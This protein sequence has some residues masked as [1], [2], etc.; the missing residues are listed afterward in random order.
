MKEDHPLFQ[1]QSLTFFYPDQPQPAVSDCTLSLQRGECF[2]LC[3]P[4]GSGKSTLLRQLKT[5][6][7]PHGRR[8]GTI[9]FRG[10]PL[11]HV[12]A[13]TQAAAIGFVTQNPENQIVTDQVWHELSFGLE[14][15][16]CDPQTIR[17]RVAET[18]SFFGIQTWFQRNVAELSGGQKQLLNLA[19]VMVMQPEV[20]ILDEPTAQL[21]PIAASDFLSALARI[22]RELGTTV[23][24]SEHRLEE[25]MAMADRAAVMSDGKILCLGT[26]QEVGQM[27]K[28]A[29][30]PMFR[31]MP[32][33]MRV[34]AAV[35]TGKSCPVTVRDGCRWLAAYAEDHPLKPLPAEAPECQPGETIL[36]AD[37]LHFRYAADGADVICGMNLTLRRG[38]LTALLGGNGTG[39]TTALKLLAGLQK[40]RCG[41]VLCEGTV[42]YLPQNPQTLFLKKTLRADLLN[43]KEPDAAARQVIRLCRLE[44]LLDRHPYDLSG[45]EQ[46]RAALAKLLM[47]QPDV[48]L[49]DEPTKGLDAEFKALFAAILR[50]LLNRGATILVASHDVEFCA[51]Y[52]DRCA[53]FFGGTVVSE[54]P[55]RQFFTGGTF[56]T[57]AA[58]R[59][60]HGAAAEVPNLPEAVTAEEL[61]AVCGGDVPDPIDLP[62]LPSDRPL[63]E[64]A[65]G[66]PND[67]AEKLPR[68]RKI[69]AVVA[70]TG[71][72]AVMAYASTHTEL[73]RPGELISK[74]RLL[75]YGALFALL[76][77]FAALVSRR[78]AKPP[79]QMPKEK[80]PKRTIA[81]SI[82][83][84]L[85]IP[86]TL[87]GGTALFD[88]RRYYLTA[89]LVL[90]ECMAPF[91]L[92]FEGR[93]PQARELVIIAVLCA[94]G[95]AGRAVFFMLPQFKPVM[96]IA[97]L[98]GAAFGGETGFL[99]GAVTMLASNL[100]FS[101]GP[102]TPWQMFAMGLVGFLAGL[103][104]K[105]GRLLARRAQLSIFGALCALIVYGGIMN[106]ASALMW[107][108]NLTWEILLPYYLTGCPMD[109]I[110]AAATAFFL[111]IAAEPMLEKLVR[112]KRKYGL[113]EFR[114]KTDGMHR[115]D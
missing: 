95:V 9:H 8:M 48:L 46:Q 55:P 115:A 88:G 53:L 82:S 32:T 21:D 57:T 98:A 111:W 114:P 3:G 19:A 35:P 12:D 84:L 92:L 54:A 83:I 85:L 59:M 17:R 16:G 112:M 14:S 69:G 105:R 1:V 77:L 2:V 25:A 7:A 27:L 49:M 99:V 18:A 109:C 101:Q 33:P 90:L 102:W 20:L 62:E 39:K 43:G 63:P 65:P 104:F 74:N 45:G 76:A 110:H 38:E 91:F 44:T 86:L 58:N 80:L 106:F 97:I 26:P 73:A 89:L 50:Q 6:L 79:V 60:V 71:V 22:N 23:L 28:N 61:M 81:A 34:W 24:L 31:S 15:L 30:H 94:V 72:C 67:P 52:A 11:D 5:V 10:V 66:T 100:F 64:P 78:S 68:W 113:A 70:L 37:A 42:C 51:T 108:T 96:A 41:S 4:S 36:Q 13:R 93:K 75:Q 87:W 103:I 56:Y 40:P 29:G 107:T 47:A